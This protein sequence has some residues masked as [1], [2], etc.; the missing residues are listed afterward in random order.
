[1]RGRWWL[2]PFVAVALTGAGAATTYQRW[3]FGRPGGYTDRNYAA[4]V[5]RVE[6]QSTSHAAQDFALHMALYRSAIQARARGF[7]LFHIINMRITDMQHSQG[8]SFGNQE[9]LL[10]A[11]GTNDPALPLVC[12]RRPGDR[13]APNCGIMRVSTT[14]AS[15]RPLLNQTPDMAEAEVAELRRSL[16]SR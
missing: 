13:F 1:M 14:L 16:E 2:M 3:Q 8:G 11:K 4:D 10:K 12:E 9:V 15:M 5:W 6:A 7:T